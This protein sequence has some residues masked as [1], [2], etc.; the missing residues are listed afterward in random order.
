MAKQ[1]Q[2]YMILD[3]AICFPLV[4]K[5]IFIIDQLWARY[6][7]FV[8]LKCP[9]TRSLRTRFKPII[10]VLLILNVFCYKIMKSLMYKITSHLLTAADNETSSSPVLA[11]CSAP[12]VCAALQSRREQQETELV[13][14][15]LQ[16]WNRSALVLRLRS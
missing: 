9:Q 7:G 2:I 15:Q 8:G 12:C 14:Q 1:K 4:L 10:V 5:S 6:K 13:E 11:V 16:V 3:I